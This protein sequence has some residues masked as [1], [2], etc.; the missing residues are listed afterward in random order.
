MAAAGAAVGRLPNP[1]N[2]IAHQLCYALLKLVTVSR[3][4]LRD[5]GSSLPVI[6][7]GQQAASGNLVLL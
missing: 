7:D 6:G 4:C 3:R 2:Q 1:A 5:F